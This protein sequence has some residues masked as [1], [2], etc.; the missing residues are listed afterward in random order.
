MQELVEVALTEIKPRRRPMQR[1]L[2][3]KRSARRFGSCI[4]SSAS[5]TADGRSSDYLI[6]TISMLA[7]GHV[8]GAALNAGVQFFG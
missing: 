6:D 1:K 4:K 3:T 5:S 7:Q 2:I 8:F